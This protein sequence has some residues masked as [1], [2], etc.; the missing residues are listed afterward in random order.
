MV[1]T[2]KPKETS[3]EYG[4]A[5]QE[6]MLDKYRKSKIVSES[7]TQY[8]RVVLAHELVNKYVLPRLKS[9]LP[10]EITLVDVGCSVGLFAIEFAKNGY[11][12][13]GVDFDPA[14]LEI[15][16]RLNLEEGTNATFSR[17]DA[18]DW[19]LNLSIDI[20]LCFD[21]FEHLHDDELG[22][23]LYGI[24]NRLSQQGCLVFH[25]L[26]LQYDYLFWNE[27]TGIIKFPAL[28]RLFKNIS[29]KSFS[30]MVAIYALCLDVLNLCRGRTVYKETIKKSGHCNPLTRERLED[31]LCRSGYEI[32]FIE[33]GFLGQVQLDPRD[34]E[35]FHKQP[36][37][38]RSLRGVAVPKRSK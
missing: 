24:K 8:L 38:H 11:K 4:K 33:S 35:F 17:M 28:L 6:L 14:A 25:T 30:R 7:N 26:P 29:T 20:A 10:S 34:R 22:A 2:L 18:S 32:I 31:I 9:K 19:N 21:L 16:K 5:H 3:F 1:E 23:L 27:A 37:T 13:F 36:V 15:A 12:S